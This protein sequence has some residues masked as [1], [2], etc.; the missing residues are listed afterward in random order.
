[1]F[2]LLVFDKIWRNTIQ[3][4]FSDK[5][6]NMKQLS[7]I[8][9]S[10]HQVLQLNIRDKMNLC[11]SVLEIE[12]KL[13]QDCLVCGGRAS[14]CQYG[15]PACEGCRG[16]FR[17]SVRKNVNYKCQYNL[18]C[19]VDA[20]R[21]KQCSVLSIP[22]MSHSWDEQAWWVMTLVLEACLDRNSNFWFHLNQ[23]VKLFSSH[24]SSFLLFFCKL[25]FLT[26]WRN[27]PKTWA[28]AFLR[29]LGTL[30][31]YNY[32]NDFNKKAYK[33]LEK[34]TIFFK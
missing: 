29:S 9:L 7:L 34:I 30:I 21:R 3:R 13:R 15:V 5:K 12:N 16:F 18:R 33:S 24:L 17:R 25:S 8:C 22:E 10:F 6:H 23:K 19:I 4:Q 1:M 2:S 20:E 11:I 31:Q 14:G 27:R 26:Q 28:G 32:D